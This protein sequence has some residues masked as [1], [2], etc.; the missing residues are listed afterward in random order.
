MSDCGSKESPWTPLQHLCIEHQDD[1]IK[2]LP[3]LRAT[4]DMEKCS[5]TCKA[6]GTRYTQ[7]SI[8]KSLDFEESREVDRRSLTCFYQLCILECRSR[9]IDAHC[10]DTEIDTTKDFLRRYYSDDAF[11]EAL[12]KESKTPGLCQKLINQDSNR[13]WRN[14]PLEPLDEGMIQEMRTKIDLHFSDQG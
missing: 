3:C 7:F 14:Q 12:K 11:H 5:G 6:A 10:A 4:S 9:I 1:F 13:P 2:I 8:E